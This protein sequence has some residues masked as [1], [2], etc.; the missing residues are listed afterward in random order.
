MHC[1]D[2]CNCAIYFGVIWNFM[3]V[4]EPPFDLTASS[5]VQLTADKQMLAASRNIYVEKIIKAT[6][7]ISTRLLRFLKT[8]MHWEHVPGSIG[9]ANK[10]IKDQAVQII[11]RCLNAPRAC[12]IDKIDSDNWIGFILNRWTVRMNHKKTSKIRPISLLFRTRAEIRNEIK[13]RD[14]LCVF[15]HASNVFQK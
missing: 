6:C 4:F 8:T 11:R 5:L 7:V 2:F 14:T 9:L 13:I 1:R 10:M 15:G 12:I 3:R